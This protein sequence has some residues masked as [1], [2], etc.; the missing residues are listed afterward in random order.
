MCFPPLAEG[1]VEP[2]DEEAENSHS[3]VPSAHSEGEEAEVDTRKRS[4]ASDELGETGDSSSTAL[5]SA[6]KPLNVAPLRSAPPAPTTKKPS[7]TLA[8]QLAAPFSS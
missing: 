1:G 7:L 6:K 3:S 4:R 5:P 8:W 2:E